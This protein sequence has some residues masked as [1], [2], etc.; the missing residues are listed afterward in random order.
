MRIQFVLRN[1]SIDKVNKTI[2]N[3]C[4]GFDVD[5]DFFKF[6][7]SPEILNSIKQKTLA[8]TKSVWELFEEKDIYIV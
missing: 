4:K 5:R 3:F 8:N 7:A 1:T 2:N 6:K